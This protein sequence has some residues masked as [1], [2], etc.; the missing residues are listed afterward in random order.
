MGE[1]TLVTAKECFSIEQDHQLLRGT[2]AS[3]SL[4]TPAAEVRAVQ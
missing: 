4:V 3:H 2:Q 1:D